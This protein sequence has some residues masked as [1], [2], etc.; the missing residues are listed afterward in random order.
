VSPSA[1]PVRVFDFPS[2]QRRMCNVALTI[3]ESL[4]RCYT[5]VELRRAVCLIALSSELT[6]AR[7]SEVLRED[8]VERDAP[9]AEANSV[10]TSQCSHRL[11]VEEGSESAP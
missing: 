10:L 9:P 11:R 1:H 4:R 7:L 3:G 5:E 6:T 8:D 2:G